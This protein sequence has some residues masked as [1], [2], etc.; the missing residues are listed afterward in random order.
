MHSCNN[1]LISVLYQYLDVMVV[2]TL[3]NAMGPSVLATWHLQLCLHFQ[4]VG[5]ERTTAGRVKLRVRFP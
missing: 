3:P 1:T 5:M 4:L 2:H